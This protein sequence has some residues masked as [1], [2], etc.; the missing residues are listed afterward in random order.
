MLQFDHIRVPCHE[1]FI[2]SYNYRLVPARA[3]SQISLAHVVLRAC[4]RACVRVNSCVRART[5]LSLFVS[6]YESNINKC[7]SDGFLVFQC[8]SRTPRP[9]PSPTPPPPQLALLPL[10][11]LPVSLAV[12]LSLLLSNA[13]AGQAE[14]E[15]HVV[16][17]S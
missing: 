4:D 2:I 17:D 7:S 6:G 9:P 14:D 12:H 5:N 15:R 3:R 10:V 11:G 1:F 16:H 13:K 8:P